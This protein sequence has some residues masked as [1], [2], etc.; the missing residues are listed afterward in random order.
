MHI[1]N[2]KKKKLNEIETFTWNWRF[3]G[4]KNLLV[5]FFQQKIYQEDFCYHRE[6]TSFLFVF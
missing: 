6:D 1:V 3:I 4:V 5:Y 2:N